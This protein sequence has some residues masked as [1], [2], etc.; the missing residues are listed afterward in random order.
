MAETME[1]LFAYFLQ[2]QDSG[3]KEMFKALVRRTKVCGV[4]Y[5]ELGFQRHL[6]KNPDIAAQIAD[7]TSQIARSRRRLRSTQSAKSSR[8]PRGEELRLLMLEDCRP[9][10]SDRARRADAQL[11][12]RDRDHPGSPVPPP[13]DVR[14]RRRVRA[15]TT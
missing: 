1:L 15:N 12:A 5:V 10:S 6:K 2:E 8:T 11:P 14:R 9:R 13:Q 7:V 4:G 3:Y